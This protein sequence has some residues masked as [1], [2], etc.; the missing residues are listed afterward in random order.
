MS[1]TP[2]AEGAHDLAGGFARRSQPVF[3]AQAVRAGSFLDDSLLF[4]LPQPFDE[5]RARH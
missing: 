5:Q 1:K 4:Q 3:V 2:V